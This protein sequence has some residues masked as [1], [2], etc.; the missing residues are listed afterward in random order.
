M[1]DKI[2]LIKNKIEQLSIL[3]D[4]LDVLGNSWSLSKN[5]ILNMNL[6]LEELISN[7]IF[8]GYPDDSEHDIKI[9]FSFDGQLIQISIED[10]GIEFNP[11][12]AKMPDLDEPL[13]SREIGGLG[14]FFVRELTKS[15]NYQRINNKN[16]L[17]LEMSV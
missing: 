11:L 7:T 5:F 10:D 3:A 8:Y 6:V 13:E 16:I 1:K 9:I 15:I 14:V 12:E 2:L 17:T 4:E